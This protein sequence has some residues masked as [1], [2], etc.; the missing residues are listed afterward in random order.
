MTLSNGFE[1]DIQPDVLDD[2]EII[3]ATA[4]VEAGNVAAVGR[5]VGMLIGA[6]NKKRLYEHIR[7]Q[8]GRVKATKVS[9][10]VAEIFRELG[11]AGKKP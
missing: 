11:E 7:R 6:E 1:V 8:E 4:E 5:L 2:M 10:C 9:E 3:E